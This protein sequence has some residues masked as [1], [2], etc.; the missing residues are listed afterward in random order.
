[1]DLSD[2]EKNVCQNGTKIIDY[3][4]LKSKNKCPGQPYPCY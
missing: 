4:V 1:M 3:M 2:W